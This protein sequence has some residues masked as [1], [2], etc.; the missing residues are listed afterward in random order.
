MRKR[1][2]LLLLLT[3]AFWGLASCAGPTGPTSSPVDE[4]TSKTS[5][6]A[7]PSASVSSIEGETTSTSDDSTSQKEKHEITVQVPEHCTYT[8]S[9]TEATKGE[10]ITLTLTPE[11]GWAVVSVTLNGEEIPVVKNEVTFVM[12]EEDV[13]LIVTLSEGY[14]VTIENVGSIEGYLVD[15]GAIVAPGEEVRLGYRNVGENFFFTGF[16]AKSEEGEI[17]I[18]KDE[19]LQCSFRMPESPV[20]VTCSAMEIPEDLSGIVQKFGVG[21]QLDTS[22]SAEARLEIRPDLT[23]TLSLTGLVHPVMEGSYTVQDPTHLSATLEEG[24]LEIDL[25]EEKI[26]K[27]FFDWDDTRD[28]LLLGRDES[29]LSKR[30]SSYSAPSGEKIYPLSILGETVFSYCSEEGEIAY[31]DLKAFDDATGTTVDSFVPGG[32]YSLREEEK[33]IVALQYL[34]GTSVS[35]SGEERGTYTLES[36]EDLVLDGFGTV[37]YGERKGRYVYTAD[38]KLVTATFGEEEILFIIDTEE[39]TYSV[40]DPSSGDAS[41]AGK[42]YQGKFSVLQDDGWTQVQYFLTLT[43]AQEEGKVSY[44]GATP[45]PDDWNS[46]NATAYEFED[47]T[48][49]FDSG[50]NILTVEILTTYGSSYPTRLEVNESRQ[51]MTML[52]GFYFLDD[53]SGT[54]LN[55]KE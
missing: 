30:G 19:E 36:G 27:V 2:S 48:Y 40:F 17:T 35:L 38:Q 55:I 5:D 24:T 7:S 11:E 54:V 44:F 18:K 4:S 21:L 26:A 8:L 52:D 43:F 33:E 10:T 37:R 29:V 25:S 13:T 34:G 41:F 6:S 22:D 16:T 46:W 12:P 1:K 42:T 28:V 47:L 51:S 9:A 32:I 45:D 15:A 53:A 49:T 14:P 23:L 39:K 20:T 50:T 31:Y 3:G